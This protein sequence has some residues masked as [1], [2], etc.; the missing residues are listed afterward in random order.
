[1]KK[2]LSQL[3]KV[4]THLVDIPEIELNNAFA[5]F[6]SADFKKGDFILSEGQICKYLY[7]VNSGLA[8]SFLLNEGKEHI[9]QFAAENDFLVDLGSFLPQKK[10]SFF[11]QAVEDTEAL[12]ISFGNLDTLFNSSFGFMKLGKIFADQSTVNLVRRS[13]SLIKDDA[14]QRYLDFMK[15]RPHLINRVPLFMIASYLGITPE[16][17]S[18]IRREIAR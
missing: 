6:E 17:L 4:L 15:E 1:M 5:Y 9:R 10:S 18:R 14:K 13:V 2:R 7:F 8:K 16:S 11:I 3:K 12:R